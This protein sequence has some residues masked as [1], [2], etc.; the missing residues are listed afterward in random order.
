MLLDWQMHRALQ[1]VSSQRKDYPRTSNLKWQQCSEAPHHLISSAVLAALLSDIAVT[2]LTLGSPKST[3]GDPPC[4][5]FTVPLLH[6]PDSRPPPLFCDEKTAP[7]FSPLLLLW[8]ARCSSRQL[9]NKPPMDKP[10]P[11]YSHRPS[12]VF[13]TPHMY[14][15]HS[16]LCCQTSSFYLLNSV[17]PFSTVEQCSPL[18]YANVGTS[19]C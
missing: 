12:Q 6:T 9:T 15:P 2:P 11:N 5:V 3:P 14:Y 7:A 17:P 16:G 13:L 4:S 18:S 19:T 8:W 10:R 1:A